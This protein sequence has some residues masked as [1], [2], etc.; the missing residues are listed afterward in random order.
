MKHALFLEPVD[1]WSFRD[2][3]PFEVGEAFEARSLFPPHPRTV[4]GCLR[5]ALLRRWCPEP[6]RYAGRARPGACP[7]CGAGPCR[8]LPLVG[9]PDGV[10]PFEIGPPLLARRE[11]RRAEVY[12]PVPRDLV[13]LDA[14]GGSGPKGGPG[15]TR[16]GLLVPLVP[17]SGASHC[18]GGLGPIG[19]AGPERVEEPEECLRFI[20]RRALEACL[21]GADPPPD[22]LGDRAPGFVR[23]PRIGIGIDAGTRAARE[24]RLYLR[25]VVRLEDGAGLLVATSEELGLD[26]DVAR[27]GGDGRMA[28]LVAVEF[29]GWPSR[30]EV[31]TRLK[32]Y[33]AAPTWFRGGAGGSAGWYPGW[34]DPERLEGIPP[35][36]QARVRLVGAAMG[37]LVPVGGWNL[38][39]QQPREIQWLVPAGSVFFFEAE[40]AGEARTAA[41]AIHGRPLCDD[42]VMA[43]AGFGLAFVG[44]W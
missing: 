19:L 8:A 3:K 2:G 11:G 31:A 37:T 33:L 24:G 27:L 40:S 25:D 39:T 22:S 18:L 41:D 14:G 21:A 6:D 10:P 35:G 23:E 9:P 30:P 36:C 5:T 32:V 26:M 16:T 12:Y 29:P 17:P 1:A 43:R 28:R 34:L 13:C 38:A 20:S 15:G 44:R 4:L 7:E 42:E